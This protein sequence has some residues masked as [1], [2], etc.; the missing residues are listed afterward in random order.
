MLP[1][2]WKGKGQFVAEG[3]TT[4]ALQGGVGTR[5]ATLTGTVKLKIGALRIIQLYKP[6][7]ESQTRAEIIS[8]DAVSRVGCA[9]QAMGDEQVNAANRC[10]LP[11]ARHIGLRLEG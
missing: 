9:S 2:G 1:V 4:G 8:R 5:E 6:T 10:S 3:G 7:C 11:E